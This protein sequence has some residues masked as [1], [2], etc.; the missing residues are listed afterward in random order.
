M[1]PS[2]DDSYTIQSSH[3][4]NKS[5]AHQKVYQESSYYEEDSSRMPIIE[6]G[7]RIPPIK[8]PRTQK[9]NETNKT[10]VFNHNLSSHSPYNIE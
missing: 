8:D 7:M 2:D 1:V 10:P 5:E 6:V 9:S 3:E 4:E